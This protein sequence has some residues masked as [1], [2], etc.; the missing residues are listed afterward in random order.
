MVGRSTKIEKYL[1]NVVNRKEC[2]GGCTEKNSIR[3]VKTKY[4]N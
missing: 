1:S 2:D 4:M 3:A